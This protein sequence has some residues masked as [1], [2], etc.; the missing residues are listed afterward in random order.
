MN[1]PTDPRQTRSWRGT[2][3]AVSGGTVLLRRDGAALAL[4]LL[5]AYVAATGGR[6]G[7]GPGSGLSPAMR[8]LRDALEAAMADNGHA[9]VRTDA[10][11]PQSVPSVGSKDLVDMKEA[12]RMLQPL[13]ERHVR[14]LAVCEAFGSVQRAGR[15]I[16]VHR[17]EVEA[18]RD[19]RKEGR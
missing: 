17:A 4:F 1:R 8:E 2:A 10:P 6:N 3:L 11:L 16:L 12:T 15:T 14:R 18:Y 9:D 7:L 5:R 19:R 13:S